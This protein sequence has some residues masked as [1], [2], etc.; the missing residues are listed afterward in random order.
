MAKYATIDVHYR[1]CDINRAAWLEDPQS[2]ACKLARAHY[3][4]SAAMPLDAHRQSLRN[5]GRQSLGSFESQKAMFS[6]H[7]KSLRAGRLQFSQKTV[8]TPRRYRY[9]LKVLYDQ[10]ENLKLM[11]F[12]ETEVILFVWLC[13][14]I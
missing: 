2:Q 1:R 3:T 12:G 4:A 14:E 13:L 9:Q 6:L 7:R 10:S 5:S 8:L 11:I